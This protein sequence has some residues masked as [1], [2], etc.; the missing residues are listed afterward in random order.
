MLF[1]QLI[2]SLFNYL[3]VARPQAGNDCRLHIFERTADH[4]DG[5][6]DDRMST[7][8]PLNC[9]LRRSTREAGILKGARDRNRNVELAL[10]THAVFIFI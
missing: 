3:D 1:T 10:N 4:G 7:W 2:E 8:A 9:D 6:G 5:D